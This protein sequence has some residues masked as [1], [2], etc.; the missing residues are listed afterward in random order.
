MGGSAAATTRPTSRKLTATAVAVSVPVLALL[1]VL[2]LGPGRPGPAPADPPWALPPL[3]AQAARGGS[4]RWPPGDG[5]A[6]G[7]AAIIYIDRECPHCKAELE[8]WDS[9][10]PSEARVAGHDFRARVRVVASPSS[11]LDD[12]EWLPASLRPGALHDTDGSI[13]EA[14]GVRLVPATFWVDASDTVRIVRV[15]QTD[16]AALT[17]NARAVSGSKE[18]Q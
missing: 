5:G 15:G 18:N 14:L 9:L 2:V 17:A 7:P 13:A 4:W 1:P 3:A 6:A 8:R 11:A 10:S 16:R 12:L